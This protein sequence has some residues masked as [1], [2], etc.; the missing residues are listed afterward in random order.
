MQTQLGTCSVV[1]DSNVVTG[2]PTVDWTD[3]NAALAGG[4]PVLFSVQGDDEIPYQVT[5]FTFHPYVVGPPEVLAYWT[6]TL[7][8]N[9]QGTTNAAA[10]Y[11]IH[12]DFTTNLHLPLLNP[13]DTQTAQI[14]SRGME[15]LDAQ[16]PGTLAGLTFSKSLVRVGDDT[17]LVNDEDTPGI[18][19]YYGTNI[20]G[21]K[22]YYPL[23]VGVLPLTAVISTVTQT[24]TAAT[25]HMIYNVLPNFVIPGQVYRVHAYGSAD[26]GTTALTFATFMTWGG[27]T[28]YTVGFN[29]TTTAATGRVWT[30]DANVVFRQ[31]GAA[32]SSSVTGDATLIERTSSGAAAT[33]NLHI[34]VLSVIT[35]LDTTVANDFIFG[36]TLTTTTG[37]P[38][39][40]T[41]GG[42]MELVR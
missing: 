6:L 7:A 4:Q 10:E 27:I 24:V 40:R 19:E 41:Q 3:A 13:G 23:P 38:A 22:G 9:Y 36:W 16:W 11:T 25:T 12:T 1:F 31:A 34:N 42:Y 14:I 18:S 21:A 17:T 33:E 32:G 35:T 37:A 26:N 28:L 2:D 30:Y 15:I 39:V 5:S 20:A 8:S 29:S